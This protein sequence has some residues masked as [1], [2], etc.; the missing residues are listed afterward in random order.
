MT[1]RLEKE[2]KLQ[3]GLRPCSKKQWKY[4]QGCDLD[5]TNNENTTKVATPIEKN[6]EIATMV[7]TLI[8]KATKLQ[9]GL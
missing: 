1:T 2:T 3:R 5:G 7:A 8:E 4:N 6:N 9:Q